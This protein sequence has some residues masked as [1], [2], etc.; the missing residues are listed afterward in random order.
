MTSSH[1]F[2]G[3]V[4]SLP[5]GRAYVNNSILRNVQSSILYIGTEFIVCEGNSFITPFLFLV[6]WRYIKKAYVFKAVKSNLFSRFQCIFISNFAI[7]R[8]GWWDDHYREYTSGVSLSVILNENCHYRISL[9]G[10]D[11]MSTG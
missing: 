8:K 10:P 5:T 1:D 2:Q 7:D 11:S 4:I 6:F 3:S 9:L